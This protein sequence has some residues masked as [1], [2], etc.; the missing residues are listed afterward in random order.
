MLTAAAL[1]AAMRQRHGR[2]LCLIDLGMPRT[3]EPSA[4]A[5][6]GVSLFN[7]DDLRRVVAEAMGQRRH[8]MTQARR[9]IDH[10]VEGFMARWRRELDATA[11]PGV[12]DARLA[13]HPGLVTSPL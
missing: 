6:E 7:I 3:I 1:R 4:A 8:A 13:A 10:Q 12:P 11:P 2:P 9:I 5:I